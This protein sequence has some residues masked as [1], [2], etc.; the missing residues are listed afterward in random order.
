MRSQRSA[1]RLNEIINKENTL[2]AKL[3]HKAEALQQIDTQLRTLL[4]SG[5]AEKATVANISRSEVI[6][7]ISSASLLTRLRMQQ[8][9]IMQKINQQFHWAKIEKVT[10]KVRPHAIPK[11]ERIR[12][13]PYRSQQ[14]ACEVRQAAEKCSAPG[15]K[16]SLIKLANHIQQEELN[17]QTKNNPQG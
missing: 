13:K 8:R 17:D 3:F 12:E 4:P 6:I 5:I 9:T 10:L 15:L 11:A 2:L 1:K 16:A 7:H 14:I